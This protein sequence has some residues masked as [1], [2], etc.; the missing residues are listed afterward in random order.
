MGAVGL[1]GGCGDRKPWGRVIGGAGEGSANGREC[2]T[3]CAPSYK[4]TLP[5]SNKVCA[6]S[7]IFYITVVC[8][9][10]SFKSC[11]DQCNVDSVLRECNVDS[12]QAFLTGSYNAEN[13][14]PI[15]RH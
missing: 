9:A 14:T 10:P 5:L 8:S 13:S 4:A 11:T 6:H 7:V 12:A 15:G 1:R 3:Q 2:N